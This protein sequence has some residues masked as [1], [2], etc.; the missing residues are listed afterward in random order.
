MNSFI[1]GG[2]AGAAGAAGQTNDTQT[3]QIPEG[4]EWL[5]GVDQALL[6]EPSIKNVKDMNSLVKSYVHAQKMIGADKVVIPGKDATPEQWNEVFTKLGLPS[7]ENYKIS[8]TEKSLL[9]DRFYNKA[10]ELGHALGILPNQMQN[11]VTKL[12]EDAAAASNDQV[13]AAKQA[14]SEAQANL[15]KEWGDAYDAKIQN[16]KMVVEKFGDD[17]VKQFIQETGLGGNPTFVKFLEKISGSMKEAKI[18][19]GK[20]DSGAPADLQTELNNIL[21]DKNN[22][23]WKRDHV[24]HAKM[25]QKVSE[26]FAKLS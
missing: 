14:F 26:L 23:Y 11:F 3:N 20:N 18:I 2:N 15:K 9:G 17:S 12:E 21:N 24:D 5:K 22:P 8:K 13:E 4:M 1:D 16:V 7:K 25:Q 6:S 19:E 10:T